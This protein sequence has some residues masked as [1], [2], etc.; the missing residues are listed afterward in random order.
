MT[1]LVNLHR[2]SIALISLPPLSAAELT[3]RESAS[4]YCRGGYIIFSLKLRHSSLQFICH[5][6][7]NYSCFLHITYV[8]NECLVMR[9]VMVYIAVLYCGFILK[10]DWLDRSTI[11][12]VLVHS[13]PLACFDEASRLTPSLCR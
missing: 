9:S 8:Q 2:L 11:V 1:P 10:T 3:M 13:S 4:T 12:A 7:L 5:R 6:H